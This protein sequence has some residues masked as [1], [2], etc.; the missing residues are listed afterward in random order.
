MLSGG[1][2]KPFLESI[3]KA[4]TSACRAQLEEE[5]RLIADI[6]DALKLLKLI[7]AEERNFKGS[8]RWL[9]GH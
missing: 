8:D 3:W 4:M 1:L 7:T 6:A 5:E 9:R 2:A